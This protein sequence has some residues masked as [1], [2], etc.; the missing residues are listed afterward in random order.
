MSFKERT[1]N[2]A[3]A[4]RTPQAIPYPEVIDLD[5]DYHP[6]TTTNFQAA[7]LMTILGSSLAFMDGSIVTVALPTLT[8]AKLKG[9]SL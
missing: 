4:I 1:V 6:Y 9:E 2:N 3:K 7:L 8:Q 5:T